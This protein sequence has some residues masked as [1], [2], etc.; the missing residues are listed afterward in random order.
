AESVIEDE[1]LAAESV[2]EDEDL[3]AESVIEDE[4]LAA[5]SANLE[6]LSLEE[7]APPQEE[8]TVA[9]VENDS[10]KEDGSESE[11]QE[12]LDSVEEEPVK[13]K[14]DSTDK[15]EN[16]IFGYFTTKETMKII[17]VI[18]NQDSLDFVNTLESIAECSNEDEADQI[19]KDVFLSY[20]VN[21][22]GKEAVLLKEK[23]EQF[24]RDKEF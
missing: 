12:K 7:S 2:I 11:D 8:E 6:D 19:I 21:S 5:E 20:R 4:D 10:F 9:Q 13:E 24:F 3:A 1:D 16:D 18:F 15:P 17:N 23:I 22:V 14:F